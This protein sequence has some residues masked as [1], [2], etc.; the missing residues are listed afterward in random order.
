[1]PPFVLYCFHNLGKGA[2]RMPV[3]SLN[4]RLCKAEPK[5]LPDAGHLSLP[6]AHAG[7]KGDEG[8]RP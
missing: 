6:C 3:A 1:M 7:G 2:M 8:H 4:A 5:M